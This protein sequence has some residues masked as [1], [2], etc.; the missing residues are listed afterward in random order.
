M[1]ENQSVIKHHGPIFHLPNAEDRR[2]E[3]TSF[4]LPYKM[5]GGPMCWFARWEI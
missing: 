4:I 1:Q 5:A 3:G 2:M